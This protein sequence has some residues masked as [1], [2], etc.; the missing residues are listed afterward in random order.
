MC[1]RRQYVGLYRHSTG[2][3][4]SENSSLNSMYLDK[5][6]ITQ[7]PFKPK[8]IAVLLKLML[9]FR[10]AL[11]PVSL[12]VHD[13]YLWCT[14]VRSRATW[15]GGALRW[16]VSLVYAL[17]VSADWYVC[18]CLRW[19]WV[20]GCSA[21]L[22]FSMYSSLCPWSYDMRPVLERNLMPN[23]RADAAAGLLCSVCLW[24]QHG[25]QEPGFRRQSS[26]SF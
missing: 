9:Y 22:A 4:I 14:S 18:F 25:C 3:R 7:N 12:T 8:L 13:N 20:P 5:L 1:R 2:W 11:K 17:Y 23:A 19:R 15:W 10:A 26:D 16:A 6:K 21:C 24:E